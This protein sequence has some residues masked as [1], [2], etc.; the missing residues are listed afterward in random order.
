MAND[1]FDATKNA[2]G[3]SGVS[4][5]SR[6]QFIVAAAGAVA[7]APGQALAATA[8]GLRIFMVPKWTTYP[9]FEAAA[10]GAKKAA[11][12]LGDT[13]TYTGPTSPNAEQQVASLQNVLVQQ[14]DVILLAAIEEQNV[15]PVLKKALARGVAV[16]TYDADT[17]PDARN[18]FCNQ[19]SYELA[20]QSY[21]D[22]ALA[23]H[24]EGG[25]SVFM[26]ASPTTVNHMQ[27]IAAMKKL[28]TSNPKYELIKPG[29]TYFVS[30]DVSQS[31]NTMVNIMQADPNV[32][33]MLSG[34]AVSVP[35]AQQAI[36]ATGH[37][38]KVWAAG[39]CLPSD[40]KKFL[41]DGSAKQ[42]M[43]WD[44]SQ[45]GYM[46]AYSAHLIK[47]KQFTPQPGAELKIPDFG[48]FKVLAD[49][50][51]DLNRPLFFTKEN[52]AQFSF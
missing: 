34:S 22:C 39:C 1:E 12:Q 13:F 30:D 32:K 35:A 38:G 21:L 33:F 36:V 19:L 6:R 45:L 20:A 47:K 8:G 51:V 3:Q 31:Y 25:D 2:S 5:V 24:P 16:V 42:F 48:D 37:A 18:L 52:V 4:A 26:A 43:M 27:Q 46:A 49:S 44:P 28:M 17:A 11:D 14:P 40:C 9:Y 15:V 41:D 10:K 23:D 29:K 7:A 50:V